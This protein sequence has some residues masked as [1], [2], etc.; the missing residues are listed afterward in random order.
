LRGYR[1]T[2]LAV[3][4]NTASL[5]FRKLWPIRTRLQRLSKAFFKNRTVVMPTVAQ[6]G[7]IENKRLVAR[8]GHPVRV[9][10]VDI[11]D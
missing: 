1:R 6:P 8:I 4:T 5:T 9:S 3:G 7:D 10:T 11:V 2:L